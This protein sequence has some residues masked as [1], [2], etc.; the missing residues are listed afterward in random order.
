MQCM[1][2]LWK[3]SLSYWRNPAYNAV[4]LFFT[5]VIA[6]LFGTVFWDFG[7]KMGQ[8]Q[9]LLNA[10]GSMYSAV[11]FSGILELCFSSASA[12][13]QTV[14]YRERA[15][16]M[17]SALPYAFGQIAVELPYTLVQATVYG[18]SVL[19]DRV[20][21]DDR[22]NFLVPFLHVLHVPVLHVLRHDGCRSDAKLPCRLDRLLG[23]LWHLEPLLQIHHPPAESPDLVEMV[24][25]DMPCRV[26]PLRTGRVA[27]W[28]YHD[29]HG[30]WRPREFLCGE[31]LRLQAQLAGCGGRG[32]RGVR[33][34]LCLPVRL[35]H[36]EAQ[37]PEEMMMD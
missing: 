37:L 12:S 20:R 10:M 11:L 34:V 27:V 32:G 26:D 24:L 25:L 19:N 5:T 35:R 17:Y 21:M 18:I 31:L 14:F 4:R 29:A 8:S 6:L 9:A 28:R 33:G 3:Q 7:G 16:G 1:A 15:A 23:V 36:H 30:R 2:C 22:Q 13:V